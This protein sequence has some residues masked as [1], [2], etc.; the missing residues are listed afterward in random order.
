MTL[1]K[2][3]IK[4][5]NIVLQV[6]NSSHCLRVLLEW[7]T[8]NR[9]IVILSSTSPLKRRK[10]ERLVYS[11]KYVTS[12]MNPGCVTL[13]STPS[14]PLSD[15]VRVLSLSSYF[16]SEFLFFLFKSIVTSFFNL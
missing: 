6:L 9:V 8:S 16:W 15:F 4:V 1:L 5:S 13:F 7:R 14:T 10:R 12:T 2:S 3:K 11:H